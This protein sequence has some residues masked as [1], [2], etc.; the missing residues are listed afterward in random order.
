ML[1]LLGNETNKWNTLNIFMD[2][3]SL[4]TSNHTFLAYDANFFYCNLNQA[5]KL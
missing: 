5:I 3:C 1:N 4:F 2:D